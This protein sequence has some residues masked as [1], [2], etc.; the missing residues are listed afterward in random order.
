MMQLLWDDIP[1]H[2]SMQIPN[3]I[4]G[5]RTDVLIESMLKCQNY[6]RLDEQEK[7]YFWSGL[8][9]MYCNQG[10]APM[11]LYYM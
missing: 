1:C 8:I 10:M 2:H 11:P 3:I 5:E 7:I 9:A 4:K 6:G